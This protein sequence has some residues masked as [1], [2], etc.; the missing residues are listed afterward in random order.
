MSIDIDKI[1]AERG[2]KN[3]ESQENVDVLER[4]EEPQEPEV[5]EPE[6]Q[7]PEVQQSQEPIAQEPEPQE[8]ETFPSDKFDGKFND[9]DEVKNVL[10]EYEEL[11]NKEP[12][13]PFKDDFI[14]KV[15]DVYNQKGDLTDFFKAHSTNWKELPA[16]QVLK[17]R[18]KEKYKDIDQKYVN[19]LWEKEKEKYNLDSD[20]DEEIE[21]GKALMERDA[22]EVRTEKIQEQE[23][24]LQPVKEEPKYTPDQIKEAVKKF[25]EV[26]ELLN[27]KQLSH[28]VGDN[29]FNLQVKDLDFIVDSLAD[30]RKLINKFISPDG[31]HDIKGFIDAANYINDPDSVRQ[32]WVDYGKTLG[33]EDIVDQDYKNTTLKKQPNTNSPSDEPFSVGLAKAFAKEGKAS[34]F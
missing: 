24:Y 30:D 26:K 21:L 12:E 5:Q 6:A 29:D 3:E 11:K 13:N 28:K 15:V 17:E 19:K 31:K 9:W 16:E 32:A 10:Q 18:F 27:K 34:K 14:K 22:N 23:G 25:P 4:S 7:E 1:L 2:V 33:K 8:P 20:D